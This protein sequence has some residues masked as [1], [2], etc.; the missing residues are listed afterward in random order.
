VVTPEFEISILSSVLERV[1]D[2]DPLS[3]PLYDAVCQMFRWGTTS[4]NMRLW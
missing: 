4:L 3:D 2:F 1:G